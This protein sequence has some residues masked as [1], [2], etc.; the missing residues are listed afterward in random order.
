MGA[1]VSLKVSE[2][3]LLFCF[4]TL[5][6]TFYS[7]R[8]LA[9]TSKSLRNEN[10]RDPINGKTTPKYVTTGVIS[11]ANFSDGDFLFQLKLQLDC[12]YQIWFY[13]ISMTLE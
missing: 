4:G 8:M 13:S 2:E 11:M 6:S 1:K 7:N 9:F 10:D 3:K 12:C 5:E